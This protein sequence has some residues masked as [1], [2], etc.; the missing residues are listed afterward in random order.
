MP[1]IAATSVWGMISSSWKYQVDYK[2]H[3]AIKALI[4]ENS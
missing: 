3:L 4:P 2:K 1:E